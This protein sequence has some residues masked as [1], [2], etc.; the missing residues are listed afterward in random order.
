MIYAVRRTSIVNKVNKFPPTLC[1]LAE[2][3]GVYSVLLELGE[4][5]NSE[6]KR[7]LH[8]TY[9]GTLMHRRHAR[10]DACGPVDIMFFTFCRFVGDDN[11]RFGPGRNGARVA[12][13]SR[14]VV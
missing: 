8:T 13:S 11:K 2:H 12:Y 6:R 7:F 3:N 4:S 9:S 14:S 10:C 1:V 5:S